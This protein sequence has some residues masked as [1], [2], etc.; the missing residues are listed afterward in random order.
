MTDL[1]FAKLL[2]GLPDEMLSEAYTAN[3]RKHR[4]VYTVSAVAACFAAVIAAAVYAKVSMDPPERI[5]YPAA[6]SR[7]EQATTTGFATSI[8]HT[9]TET[10]SAAVTELPAATSYTQTGTSAVTQESSAYTQTAAVSA[11][12]VQTT[13][14]TAVSTANTVSY[15]RKT[16]VSSAQ[17]E[18]SETAATSGFASTAE[19]ETTWQPKTSW[20]PET[21]WHTETSTP[22][23]TETYTTTYEGTTGN[24]N[25]TIGYETSTYAATS[26]NGTDAPHAGEIAFYFLDEE[27]L[28][29]VSGVQIQIFDLDGNLLLELETGDDSLM[30]NLMA[31]TSYRLYIAAVPD[32]Y[33]LPR[34]NRLFKADDGDYR[35]YLNHQ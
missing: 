1:E 11:S 7:R 15:T 29:P 28:E 9:V 6:T 25:T 24:Y 22:M 10:V 8:P 12:T 19:A 16:T 3:R 34:R 21:S 30:L 23:M 32:G 17:T 13:Y 18:R 2:N 31:G 33:Q 20:E 5:D 35:I 4:I 26:N 14:R 27:T